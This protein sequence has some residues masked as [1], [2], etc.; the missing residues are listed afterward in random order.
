MAKK[1][2]WPDT[3]GTA[4]R[5]ALPDV[6]GPLNIDN[7]GDALAPANDM[8]EVAGAMCSGEGSP[9][10][11]DIVYIIETDGTREGGKRRNGST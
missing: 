10:P 6:L 3:Y 11:L 5:G 2:Q 8:A 4:V 1:S 9:D 7:E